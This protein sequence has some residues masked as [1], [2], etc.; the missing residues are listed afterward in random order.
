MAFHGPTKQFGP[1][2]C[3]ASVVGREREREPSALQQRLRNTSMAF[4]KLAQHNF[5]CSSKRHYMLS[6]HGDLPFLGLH[7]QKRDREGGVTSSVGFV[8]AAAMPPEPMPAAIFLYV[9]H[10]SFQLL[11]CNASLMGAYSPNLKP[12]YTI[13]RAM[14]GTTPFHRAKTPAP[15]VKRFH[16]V[17]LALRNTGMYQ[18]RG[19]MTRQPCT[20]V[21]PNRT[22]ARG[23]PCMVEACEQAPRC[24]S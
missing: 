12:P 4:K 10:E 22:E 20:E 19:S 9:D 18:T 1:V 11:V 14:A 8:M 5:W 3:E 7:S 15:C 6:G 17:K 24:T 2:G 23:D 13:P 21:R 16:S